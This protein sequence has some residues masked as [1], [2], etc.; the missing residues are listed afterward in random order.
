MGSESLDFS[1]LFS[2]LTFR[3]DKLLVGEAGL[4][5]ALVTNALAD[6]R[7][8][9]LARMTKGQYQPTYSL[10]RNIHA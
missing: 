3:N 9:D 7:V 8:S 4:Q 6:V 1:L 5:A 2:L 10:G